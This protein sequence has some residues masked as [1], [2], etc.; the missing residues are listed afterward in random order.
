MPVQQTTSVLDTYLVTSYALL[1][2]AAFES[3]ICFVGKSLPNIEVF[4]YVFISV[5]GFI[6]TIFAIYW[7]TVIST[8]NQSIMLN[9]SSI[10][11]PGITFS[12]SSK[13]VKFLRIVN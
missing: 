7:I 6:W 8:D 3:T 12:D 10:K 1:S 9:E 2:F 5:Y 11:D 13:Q 4:E